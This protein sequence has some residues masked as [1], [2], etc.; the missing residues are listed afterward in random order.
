MEQLMQDTDDSLAPLE[1]LI[2]VMAQLRGPGGCPWDREQTFATIAPY[3]LE[4]AHEVADAIARDAMDDLCEELGDLLLQVVFHAQIAAD[5]GHFTLADVAGGIVAK[6]IRRHPHVFADEDATTAAEV[7]ATWEEIKAAEKPRASAMDGVALALPAL[8]RAEKL[9][10]RAARAG[11]DWPDPSGPRAKID[12]ELAE[13]ADAR[14]PAAV[15]EEAGDPCSR[16]SIICGTS[17]STPRARY[18][19]R[20]RSSRSCTARSKRIRTS[21]RSISTAAKRCGGRPSVARPRTCSGQVESP[22]SETPARKQ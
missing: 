14:T 21:A 20:M 4:E 10:S 19:R 17:G 12:E 22:A 5:S 11:F 3:T 7:R 8:T 9:G 18:V 1:R 6:M 13:L 2:A 15:T 16:S